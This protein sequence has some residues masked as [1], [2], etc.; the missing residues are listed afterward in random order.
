MN[1]QPVLKCIDEC[2]TNLERLYGLPHFGRPELVALET[3]A[4]VD[5][6]L[7]PS[8][9][10]WEQLRLGTKTVLAPTVAFSEFEDALLEG[11]LPRP[12]SEKL[13][14]NRQELE[15]TL[16]YFLQQLF[17]KERFWEGQ[18]AILRQALQHKPVVGLLPTAAGKSL[19]Y[20]IAS[21]LQPGLTIV[22]QPLRSLMWDQQDNLDAIGVHRSTAIMGHAE[23]TPD[24]E[25][26]LREEG[27]RAVPRCFMWVARS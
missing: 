11:A 10:A 24:E 23:V 12:I 19:C 13:V 25:D 27:Y 3:D 7:L 2:L 18:L 17:R 6:F 15:S 1:L 9:Q 22:I 8:A 5:Y 21:L 14:K 20:Q 26:R 16:V 4:D